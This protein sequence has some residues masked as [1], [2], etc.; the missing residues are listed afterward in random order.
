MQEKLITVSNLT[1]S[2]RTE[3]RSGIENVSFNIS[4]GDVVAV[5]GES[6]S[7][8]STLLKCIYG[9]LQPDS[10]E[11]LFQDKKVKGPQEQLVPGHPEMRMVAQ[12]FSLN[13]YAKVYDNIASMLSNT[14]VAAKEAKTTGI[15]EQLH[16]GHLKDKKVIELSGGEQQRVAIARALV[17]GTKVLLLDEPFSQVDALLKNE[18]RA[19]LKL[20]AANT[21][22][23]IILVSHDPADG[24]F[25]ANKVVIIKDG[26]LIEQ[27]RPD[28]IYNDPQNV[29]TARMLGNANVLS[30]SEARV[31]GIRA[32]K[33]N[34]L[35]YPE[36]VRLSSGWSSRRFTVKNIYFKGF[37]EELLL[38][39]NGT[40]I[41]AIHTRSG[42]FKKDDTV[43][44][45]V[46]RFVAVDQ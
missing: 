9:L 38:E 43:Q 13:I 19:D 26:I 34:V 23:T 12:D 46:S 7:G 31:I 27:G 45:E 40:Y 3:T 8:K 25:L 20:L 39:R 1:K 2:Y 18:L 29:Y 41:R 35:F 32:I 5:I 42:S 11:I 44:V 33:E 10:G 22:I 24:L 37:Y 30:N 17:P 4:A 6:G 16:I 28:A 21:G 36:W 14:N 15:M